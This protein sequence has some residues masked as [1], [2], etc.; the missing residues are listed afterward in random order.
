MAAL[1]ARYQQEAGIKALKVRHNN[2][3]GY[4]IEVP[5]GASKPMLS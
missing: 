1:E 4:Y 2:I 3:L 5:A